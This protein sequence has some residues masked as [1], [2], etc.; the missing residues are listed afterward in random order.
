MSALH[1][2]DAGL[3]LATEQLLNSRYQAVRRFAR[4]NDVTLVLPER[5]YGEL[6]VVDR[7]SDEVGRADTALATLAAQYP[8]TG[9]ATEVY[10][11][12]YNIAA[13]EGAETVLAS[14]GCGDS[15]TLVNGYRFI[16]A[17]TW[18]GRTNRPT[19]RSPEGTEHGLQ[20]VDHRF[21]VRVWNGHHRSCWRS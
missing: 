17:E 6:T 7:P 12:T 11:Y 4:H 14:E 16:E 18:R 13:G 1:I 19:G 15:V 9:T 2:G 8:S 20:S 21:A 10:I 5:V 3:F